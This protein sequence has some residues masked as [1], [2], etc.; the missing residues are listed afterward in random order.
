[1]AEIPSAENSMQKVLGIMHDVAESH[2]PT[3]Q[4]VGI[5]VQPPPD[6][7]VKWNNIELTKE[8]IYIA[9]YLLVGYRREARGHIV[10]ATQNRSGGSGDAAYASHN[11][12]IDNDYTDDII[13]TDTLKPGDLVS[14]LPCAG[15][16]LYI[17][18]D[19]LVKL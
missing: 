17:I 16:Q 10:S 5:I 13:Y 19:K 11:H 2:V 7:V 6:I 15:S 4:S 18:T 9:E 14:V 12:D 3:A 8:N 1:M